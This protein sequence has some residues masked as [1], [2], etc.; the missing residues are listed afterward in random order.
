MLSPIL[1]GYF[2][3]EVTL[4]MIVLSKNLHVFQIPYEI[5]Y[6]IKDKAETS[7]IIRFALMYKAQIILLDKVLTKQ[8]IYYRNKKCNNFCHIV[9]TEQNSPNSLYAL[10]FYNFNTKKSYFVLFLNKIFFFK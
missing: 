7:N 9:K 1:K 5:N 8:K 6:L 3:C 4:L 2:L 10:E